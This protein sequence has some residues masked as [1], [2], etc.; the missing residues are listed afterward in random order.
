MKSLWPGS[1]HVGSPRLQVGSWTPPNPRLV[2]SEGRPGRRRG[3]TSLPATYGCDRGGGGARPRW[4]LDL[5]HPPD[6]A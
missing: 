2:Q 1:L 4:P 3:F 5:S 6:G